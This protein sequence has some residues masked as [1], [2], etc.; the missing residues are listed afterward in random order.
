MEFNL[1][2]PSTQIDNS[3]KDYARKKLT[4]AL[5][6]VVGSTSARVDVEISSPSQSSGKPLTKVDVHV[7][8]PRAKKQVVNVEAEEL[9]ECIDLATDKIM[10]A[11]KRDRNRRRDK[12]RHSGEFKIAT[13]PLDED[14]I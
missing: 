4:N 5:G 8:I 11:V 1:R 9:R 6:K 2:A 7:F 12:L 14:D 10:R 3:D 13:S